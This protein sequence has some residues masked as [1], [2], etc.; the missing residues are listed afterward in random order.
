MELPVFQGDA[1]AMRRLLVL[2]LLAVSARADGQTYWRYSA[3]VAGATIGGSAGWMFYQME[4]AACG[5]SLSADCGPTHPELIWIL[6]TAGGVGGYFGGLSVDRTLDR[7]QTLSRMDRFRLKGQL[8]V[9]SML[10]PP[11]LLS[12]IPNERTRQVLSWYG[13]AG[14]AILGHQL[15]RRFEPQMW[16]K[17]KVGIAPTGSGVALQLSTQW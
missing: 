6:A 2:A 3:G 4:F 8:V 5:M 11:I 7:G 15:V 9:T 16:P 14:G 1:S 10:L 12:P 13:V 17:T